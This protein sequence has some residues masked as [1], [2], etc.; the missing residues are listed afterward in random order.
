MAD[1]E[2]QPLDRIGIAK[3]I[4]RDIPEGWF[5]NLG[6]G[7]PT[8]VSDFVPQ[9]REVIFHAENGVIGIGPAPAPDDINPFL[10]NAG[11]QP[12]TLRTGGAYVHHA[13]SFGI[14]RGGHLDLCVLGAFQVGENG[15][16]ANWAHSRDEPVKQVGGAMDLAVGAKRLWVAMEHNTKNG[17]ARILRR[18]TYPLTARG[19]VRRIYTDL[20]VLDVTPNGLVVR[21]MVPGLTFEALQGRTEAALFLVS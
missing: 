11:V 13:D 1:I 5:V 16:I 18:C 15:D 4:A 19:V 10:V 17:H 7:I 3:R 2:F 14:A 8:T 9:D 6:I 20:A 12:I 21:D